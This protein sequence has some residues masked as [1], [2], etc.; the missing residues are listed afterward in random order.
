MGLYIGLVSGCLCKPALLCA[1]TKDKESQEDSH[2]RIPLANKKGGGGDKKKT[3]PGRFMCPP[4]ETGSA[5]WEHSINPAASV[6][7]ATDPARAWWRPRGKQDSATWRR[8]ITHFIFFFFTIA[9]FVLCF[10][11]FADLWAPFEKEGGL[12]AA[13][14]E[15]RA[16]DPSA[17]SPAVPDRR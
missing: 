12:A 1:C 14:E 3:N 7:H 5:L 13:M 9:C 17:S 2:L 16:T 15:R 6:W 11:S 10:Q 8:N 4:L